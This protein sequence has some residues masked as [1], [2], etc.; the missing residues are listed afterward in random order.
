MK[1]VNLYG[2]FASIIIF[3]FIISFLFHVLY[4]KN[5]NK[6]I[7]PITELEKTKVINILNKSIDINDYQ[8]EFEN[9]YV[10]K[11]KTLVKIKLMRE[12]SS[13]HYLIDI[14]WGKILG[15]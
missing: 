10:L 14:K 1:R 2:V 7:R 4:F 11:N 6:N 9:V 12:D 15:K 8:I 5:L 3:I 13:E